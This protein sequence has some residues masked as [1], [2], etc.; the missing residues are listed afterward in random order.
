[1]NVA[2]ERL[3]VRWHSTAVQLSAILQALRSI[4]Y[5]AYPYDA[6]RHEEQLRKSGRTLGRQLFVAGLSMMQVMMYAAPAYLAEDGTLDADMAAL[7][8]WASLL[9]TMPAVVYSA[10][11]FFRGAWASLRARAL[12]YGCAG[13]ARHRR[14]SRRQRGGHPVRGSGEVYFDSVTMFVFLLLASRYLELHGAAQGGRR[15][16]A[17][18]PCAARFGHALRQLAGFRQDRHR[19]CRRA[20]AGR[21]CVCPQRRGVRGR[22]RHC[23]G[24]HVA[25]TWRC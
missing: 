3:A 22:R 11:P 16:G 19:Q 25:S 5:T 24:A 21:P 6:A 20:G 7:M 1:M 14:R 13:G 2:T 9:L 15:A 10:Q 17:H 18:A 12:G 4:G 8:R 23:R